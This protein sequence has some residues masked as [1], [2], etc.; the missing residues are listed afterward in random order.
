MIVH[1]HDELARKDLE[2]F[3]LRKYP[4]VSPVLMISNQDGAMTLP[5]KV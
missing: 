5:E 4:Q 2:N 3:L 1:G